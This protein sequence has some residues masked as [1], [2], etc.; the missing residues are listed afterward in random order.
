MREFRKHAWISP[1]VK[2][3]AM[4]AAGIIC[5]AVIALGTFPVGLLKRAAENRLS[6]AFG[7]PVD[8]GSLNRAEVFSFTPEI[9]VRDLRIG[10]PE[11]AGKGNFVNVRRASARIPVWPLITGNVTIRS[12]HISGL[13]LALVRDAQGNSNWAGK[14]DQQRSDGRN[15]LQLEQLII[16]DSR[17]SLRDGKRRLD[18][19]GSISADQTSGLA[20][21]AAG[22]FNDSPAR[23]SFSGGQPAKVDA[24]LGWPFRARL[25]SELLVLAAEGTMAGALNTRDM[26]IAIQA[27]APSLKQLDY[28][29][30]A[31]LFG[32]QY[33]DLN[34]TV[35]H[36]GEDWFIDTLKGTIGQSQIDAKGSV[37]KRDERSLIDATIHSSRL[38][39]DDLSDHAG[40]AEARAKEARIGPRIIPDTRIDLSRMGPTDGKIRFV[41]DRLVVKGGSAFRGLRGDLSLQHR[42]LRLDNVKAGLTSGSMT[43]WVQVDSTTAHPVLSTELRVEGTSLETLIGEPDII[44]GPLRG[45]IRIT[46]SG[47]TIREAFARGDGK[48]AFVASKGSTNRTAAFVLGRDLGGA[49]GQQ[50]RDGDARASLLCAVLSFRAEDG[51]LQPDPVVIATN[52]SDGHGSGQ[53]NLDGETVALVINGSTGRDA[54]LKL[55][56]PIRVGGTL[57]RPTIRIDEGAMDDGGPGRGIARAI[58]R[59]IGSALGLRGKDRDDIKRSAGPSAHCGELSASALR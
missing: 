24:G 31:G 18:L 51:V 1:A 48:I 41:I 46:G 10:Q 13:S 3:S 53:I 12:L 59:S 11:G 30:E 52:I 5:I 9:S 37:I 25:S 36:R 7:A 40:L 58:G 45:L 23:L 54:A 19:A 16:E 42:V 50:L 55:A 22:T 43:G 20:L 44:S 33:I 21:N 2:K 38:D 49:I 15:P 32:T 4:V 14:A 34:S 6:S 47:S 29:I 57:S 35:R 39:F 56:N 17:F 8:I 28:I 26:H 27:R